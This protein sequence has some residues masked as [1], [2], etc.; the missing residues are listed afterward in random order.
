MRPLLTLWPLWPLP[1]WDMFEVD[2]TLERPYFA[3][4]RDPAVLIPA[5]HEALRRADRVDTMSPMPGVTVFV[6]GDGVQDKMNGVH[7]GVSF[8]HDRKFFSSYAQ[9]D[10]LVG[11]LSEKNQFHMAL[12][13]RCVRDLIRACNALGVR[14]LVGGDM[15]WLRTTGRGLRYADGGAGWNGADKGGIPFCHNACIVKV[16]PCVWCRTPWA[17]GRCGHAPDTR[18]AVAPAAASGARRRA[19]VVH[20]AYGLR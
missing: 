13:A 8:C 5:W 1:H 11:R 9:Q 7:V 3:A 18:P 6:K 19:Q 17:M 20:V 14:V 16:W 15:E 12:V 4:S 2:I 10:I